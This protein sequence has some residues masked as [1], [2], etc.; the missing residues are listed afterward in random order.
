MSEFSKKGMMATMFAKATA[1]IN[2]KNLQHNAGLARQ[3]APGSKLLAV[4]KANAY[5][6]GMQEIVAALRNDADG[7]AVA[8]FDE[9]IDLRRIESDKPALILGGVYTHNELES[10]LQHQIDIVVHQEDQLALLKEHRTSSTHRVAVWLKIDTGMHRLGITPSL[11]CHYY[12]TLSALPYIR[13]VI[14]MT[15][16]SSA[17]DLSSEH[18]TS[19]LEAFRQCLDTLPDDKVET[20][21]A[22]SA[23]LLHWPST[24]GHWVR[25]GLMLYGIN[26]VNDQRFALK[27]VMGLHAPVI[28]LRKIGKGES[29]G[30]NRTWFAQQESTVATVALGYGDGYPVQIKPG[31][32][33]LINGERAPIIGRVS[34]DLIT[35]DCSR[36][37]HAKTGDTV[38]FWGEDKW[39]NHLPV[40]E[41]ARQAQTIPYDIVTKISGRV[42]YSY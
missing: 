12:Q 37:S 4:V 30:Y 22:N 9:A 26:P 35:V 18:T 24:H 38:T 25:P 6:H 39:G 17:D 15:H 19:Q 11:A 27:P 10:C 1:T 7:F 5:G 42:K 16:F 34:M 14:V 2:L 31:A 40:E 21:L 32:P 28:S 36:L 29:V 3:H 13:K 33:V 41:I 8:R 23:A 20:S